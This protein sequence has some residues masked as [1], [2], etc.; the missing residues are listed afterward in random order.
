MERAD[1]YERVGQWM[2]GVGNE[3]DAVISSRVR[4]A[5]NA[6]GH[7]FMTR[8]SL[9]E[10]RELATKLRAAVER[11][12][13]LPDMEYWDLEVLPPVDRQLLVERHLTSREHAEAEGPR[14]VAISGDEGI[15]VMINE[16]DHLRAQVLCG[17]FALENAWTIMSRLDAAIEREVPYAFDPEFG[18]LT[19]CPTNVGT[20]LRVSVMLHLPALSMTRELQRVFTAAAKIDFIVRGLYG[21]G[22]QGYGDFFQISNQKTLGRSE[23]EILGN[24]VTVIPQVI[25]YERKVRQG[26]FSGHRRQ[27]EDRIWRAHGILRNARM[28]SSEETLHLLSQLRLGVNLGLVTDLDMPTIHKLFVLTQPAHLQK[29]EGRELESQERDA[30]R[31]DFLRKCLAGEGTPP[32]DRSQKHPEP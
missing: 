23:K 3:S 25:R 16:E 4:L 7:R 8:A 15:S 11:T 21:E 30:V 9:E 18:Y 2:T 19:A 24:L 13:A 31:A 1:L 6:A 27:V 12:R 14:G 26:M 17:G 29:I 22:T 32:H 28:I 10:R 5:R 20:G